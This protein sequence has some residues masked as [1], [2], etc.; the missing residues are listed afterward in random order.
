LADGSFDAVINVEASHQYS[1]LSRFLDEVARVLRPGGHFLYCDSRRAPAVAAWE[2]ALAEAPLRKIL[3]RAID[4]ECRRG[5]AANAQRTQEKLARRLPAFVNS[6]IGYGFGV[7][8]RDLRR[9]G[10]FTYR[11]YCFVKD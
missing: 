7:L 3:E 1:C 2:A 10:G 11:A 6:L 4:Q 9:A 5:L 8:D